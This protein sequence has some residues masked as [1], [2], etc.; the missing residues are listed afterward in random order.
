[1]AQNESAENTS[2][3][4]STGSGRR[5]TRR[6]WLRLAGA[7][8]ISA[9]AGC[10][11]DDTTTE[12]DSG[13]DSDGMTST[14]TT[15]GAVQDVTTIE[16]WRWPHSTDPSNEGEDRIVE[17]FNSG[18]G[19]DMGIEVQQ[20]TNPFGDHRT[21]VKTAIGSNNAPDVAWTFTNQYYDTA[22]KDRST[23]EEEAPYVYIEDY[24]SDEWLGDFYEKDLAT[25][26]AKYGGVVGAPFISGLEPGLLY[27]NV[28]AWE[29][30]GLGEL[31]SDTWS[32]QEYLDAVEAIDGTTVN[33]TT[34]NGTGLGLK[35][36]HTT[37]WVNYLGGPDRTAGELVGNAF[38]RQDDSYV[39]TAASTP[40]LEAWNTFWGTPIEEG[41]TINPMA[42]DFLETQEPFAA[43]QIGILSHTTYSRVQFG[44]DAEI[45]WEIIPYPTK[46]GNDYLMYEA[47]LGNLVISMTTFKEE[48][49]AK[50]EAA[51]EFIK[52]RN[53]ARNQYKWF[54]V[55]SQSV[56][57]RGAYEL[58]ESE[59]VSDF[60]EQTG[61]KALMDRIDESYR[62]YQELYDTI[63]SRWP[64]IKTTE[65]GAPVRNSPTGI[66]SGRV[67]QA[68]GGALQQLAQSN[69][70]NPQR[71]LT[72]AETEWANVVKEV[73][74]TTVAE[75]SIG[76]N[77]PEP[78]AGSN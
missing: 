28:D 24:V 17:E 72:Q 75:D 70:R 33:G 7:T 46:G 15:T 67:G 74:G 11:G 50:P 39:L 13:G 19:A 55:S 31:P 22:G 10:G 32:W 30:A 57:N 52:F 20:V 47:G 61:G 56:P 16:Y 38:Q 59:G 78:K 40:D 58:M 27:V 48:V 29:A 71:A 69:N 44:Q 4:I 73:E 18:P 60:V 64:D 21:K 51:A 35:D 49:G 36:A 37:E 6:N 42:Y 8:S 34:V 14:G 25:Q 76:W 54:N 65:A 5:V 53:N 26:R 77:K 66:G 68:M 63:K 45:D 1:M 62:N 9:L 41:W 12:G 43:G 2:K 3:D 23:I